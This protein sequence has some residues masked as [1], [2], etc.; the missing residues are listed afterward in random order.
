MA[1]RERTKETSSTE[2][3]TFADKEFKSRTV[4]LE[5]GRTFA[6]EKSLIAATDL[7]L[8]AYLDTHAD[9]ERVPDSS[10]A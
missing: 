6:V 2:T 1:N 7:A 5:D 9:F 8:I 3:V 4:V 10:E